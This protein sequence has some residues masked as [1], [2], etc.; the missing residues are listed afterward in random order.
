M[1]E[2]RYNGTWGGSHIEAALHTAAT[3]A[4]FEIM[5]ILSKY[6]SESY[7]PSLNLRLNQLFINKSL[8]ALFPPSYGLFI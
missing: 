4:Y 3:I 6:H 7:I 8:R 5:Y 2:F 1:T